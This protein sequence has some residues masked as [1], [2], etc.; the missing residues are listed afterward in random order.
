[1]FIEPF[2]PGALAFYVLA[3]L[4]WLILFILLFPFFHILR[5][6]PCLNFDIPYLLPILPF[7]PTRLNT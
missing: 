1:M 7:Y 2:S 4:H 6:D 3:P 5:K